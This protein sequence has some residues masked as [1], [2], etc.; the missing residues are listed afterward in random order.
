MQSGRP[1]LILKKDVDVDSLASLS[2]EVDAKKIKKLL[3]H[4]GKYTAKRD[5]P[6]YIFFNPDLEKYSKNLDVSVK[7]I[8]AILKLLVSSYP[9]NF[10]MKAVLDSEE[11]FYVLQKED[12]DEVKEHGTLHDPQNPKI[13][14]D[15]AK[16]IIRHTFV[17]ECCK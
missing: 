1:V 17:L 14:Y 12:L 15:N 11:M 13:I 4:L 6:L 16:E 3:D 2:K 10:K 5:A 7:D 9:N 8:F